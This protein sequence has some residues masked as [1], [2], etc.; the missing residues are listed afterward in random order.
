MGDGST[1]ETAVA[2]SIR[3][4]AAPTGRDACGTAVD[5]RMST[6]AVRIVSNE[7]RPGEPCRATATFGLVSFVATS[8][9]AHTKSPP[10]FLPTSSLCVHKHATQ[11]SGQPAWLLFGNAPHSS[12]AANAHGAFHTTS[13]ARKDAQ[14]VCDHRS[15]SHYPSRSRGG[16]WRPNGA[17]A[18]RRPHC[19]GLH[20][21]PERSTGVSLPDVPS[22]IVGCDD[23][24]FC[25][26]AQLPTSASEV[27]FR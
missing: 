6:T 21:M 3:R 10:P 5:V 25:S 24:K 2:Q 8:A 18:P 7:A 1:G 16:G 23:G 19:L 22:S 27:F 20:C 17:S 4:A 14:R 26:N 9:R 11:A 15:F 13:K 12:Q